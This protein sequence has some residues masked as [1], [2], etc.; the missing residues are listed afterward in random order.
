[1][2]SCVQITLNYSVTPSFTH[3]VPAAKYKM[4]SLAGKL[5]HQIKVMLTLLKNY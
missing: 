5:W 4:F 2:L 1:M 3:L